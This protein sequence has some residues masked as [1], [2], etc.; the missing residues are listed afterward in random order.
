MH[1]ARGDV[2]VPRP[3]L[4]CAGGS[5]RQ[6]R[7]F[8]FRDLAAGDHQRPERHR[9]QLQPSLG[10]GL[11]G[12]A[13]QA[14]RLRRNLRPPDRIADGP[15][16]GAAARGAGCQMREIDC[17][18]AAV[19]GGGG[20][21]SESSKKEDSCVAGVDVSAAARGACGERDAGGGVG[22]V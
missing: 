6:E 20:G 4:S 13:D 12:A 7:R 11:G 5:Q 21:V 19:H 8:Q 14:R 2:R 22:G 1:A 18:E 15:R 3:V 9:C 16:G 10:G 17:R